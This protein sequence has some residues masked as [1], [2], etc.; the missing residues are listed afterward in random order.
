MS[1]F[2]RKVIAS[3]ISP[4]CQKEGCG[5]YATISIECGKNGGRKKFDVIEK[6]FLCEDC[7]Q[8]YKTISG[9]QLIW[10]NHF[11]GEI[12]VANEEA[13]GLAGKNWFV[14]PKSNPKVSRTWNPI[15]EE[16]KIKEMKQRAFMDLAIKLMDEKLV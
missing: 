8:E 3:R 6:A 4:L 2:S 11:I 16:R 5:N 1:D 12:Q 7:F 10:L 14:T 15:E 13:F 9:K